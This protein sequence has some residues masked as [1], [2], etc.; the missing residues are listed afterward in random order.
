MVDAFLGFAFHSCL[1]FCVVS[2]DRLT[3][4]YGAPFCCKCTTFDSTT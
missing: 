3:W 4:S 1:M 2:N